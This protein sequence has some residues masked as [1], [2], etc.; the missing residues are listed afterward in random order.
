M[1]C[2]RILLCYSDRI[3][4]AFCAL[5]GAVLQT[6]RFEGGLTLLWKKKKL[7][8]KI[9]S[10]LRLT[11]IWQRAFTTMYAHDSRRSQ[12]AIFISDMPKSILLNYGLSQEY[13]GEFHMRFD[14]TNPTK[15]KTEFVD[16]I[17]ADIQW[18]GAVKVPRY[19]RISSAD[20]SQTNA[21]PFLISFTAASY[22][23]ARTEAKYSVRKSIWHHRTST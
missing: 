3:H 23:C 8:P 14:D 7:F 2:R 20:R 18:L 16:S 5:F 12:T 11:K 6:K 13:N 21:F 9:L 10:S 17:K 15:E 22:I 4:R 19:S 1:L